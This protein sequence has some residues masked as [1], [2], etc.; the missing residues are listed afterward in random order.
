MRFG[1]SEHILLLTLH[2]I[3]FDGWSMG[4]LLKELAV[5][6]QAFCTGKPST[7]S[8]LPIQYADFAYWQ[9]QHLQGE[10]LESQLA[11]WKTQLGGNLSVLELPTDKRRSPVQ[12][13]RGAR[14]HLLL[15][16]SLTQSL[17]VLSQREGATLFMTLLAA[18]QILLYRYTG[19]DDIVVGSPIA[20]RNRT[21]T[22]K[23]IGVFIN[24]LVLRTYIDGKLGFRE[25][26]AQVR[27]IA[28]DAFAH[29]CIP[30]EKLVEELQQNRDLS[31]TPLFQVLFQL[32]NVPNE[33]A[34]VQGL[35]FEDFQFNRGIAAFDLTLDIVD[36]PAGL[37]CQFEYNTDLFYAAT[38]DRMAGHFQTLLEGIV[39]N[40]EQPIAQLPILTAAEQHKLLVEWNNTQT[41]YPKDKC[42]HQLFEAQV[43]R[44][45]DALVVVFV[46]ERSEA[47][48]RVDEQLTYHELNCRAN[49]LA[50][51]LRSLGVTPE[52]L[53]GICVERS[54]DMVVGLLAIL[55]AGGAYVPLDPEYPQDRLSFM[56]EDAQV[57]V[58]LTQQHLVERLPQHQAQLVCLDEL[59][60]QIAQKYQD[61][62]IS[63][64]RAFHLANVIYTS[65]S[66]GKPKGV[67]VE[68]KGLVNLAQ[69]QIQTFGLHSDS[70]VLQFASLSFDA[71]ISEVVMAVGSG[72]TLYLGTKDSLLLGMP[73]IQL[74]RDYCITHVTLPPSA[75][76]VLPVE[77]LPTLQTII[78]AGEACSPELITKWSAG[79]NFFNAYGPTEIRRCI[80]AG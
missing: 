75:L 47:S 55:K 10:V 5:V 71:S 57:G 54:L 32:R 50:H 25:L 58:L 69:A 64:V 24:T 49:Q 53:V 78:V 42:I 39:A 67:M 48:R 17:M 77:E 9:R 45:P 74:L 63:G 20:G 2:H 52:V 11:Y 13:F 66:T 51:Y 61:N 12:T 46:D 29:S 14:Q 18:F 35:R 56:L 30:F 59:W 4:V 44:T 79:R 80:N 38:I 1:E 70:R 15:P 37:A 76:S 33:T 73:L 34:E 21:E 31:H 60:K 26:L 3:I 16:K 6:Y 72:A 23:L 19:S 68:H 22:E 62:P 36:T 7:L 65:G 27:K 8:E 40:L 28:I 41:D 43:E